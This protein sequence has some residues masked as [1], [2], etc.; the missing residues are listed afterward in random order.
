MPEVD[1]SHHGDAE[2]TPG[3]LDFAVNVHG[4]EPPAWLADALRGTVAD[5]GRYPDAR[6][7][8]EA[9]AALHGVPSECVLVTA[10]AAEAFT[11]V[12]GQPWRRPVVVHPQFTE[13]EAALAAHGHQVERAILHF[14]NGFR[15]DGLTLPDDADLVVL[16]NPTNPTSRLHAREQ[17]ESLLRPG[18]VVLVDEAFM[19]AVEAPE[20]PTHSLVPLAA[21]T[22]RLVVVRSLTKT[23]AVAGLRIGYA[24]G[25]PDTLSPLASRQPH[26]AVGSLAVAAAVACAG[27]RGRQHGAVFR[28]TLAERRGRLVGLLGAHGF[29]VVEPDGPFVLAA[30]PE[31]AS[32]REWLRDK[33]IAV[34]RGDTFPGLG[35]TYLRFAVRDAEAV[36]LL[37]AALADTASPTGRSVTGRSAVA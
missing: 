10:G 30:H 1:L 14:R 17:V 15:L 22:P 28:A 7:A 33:G 6:P 9:L 3:L 29:D 27:K 5:L 25:T 18:R 35:P 37:A 21:R 31:A 4:S 20:A 2:A 12:A 16:G 24:V 26:W 32:L 34:R 23:F 11:L 36:D 13:P 8:Q 19:D